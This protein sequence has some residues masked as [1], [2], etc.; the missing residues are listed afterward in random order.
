MKGTLAR[1]GWKSIKL[2]SHPP[3]LEKNPKMDKTII[4]AQKVMS[5]IKY[6]FRYHRV[7][8]HLSFVG[9][10]KTPPNKSRK[11]RLLPP[12]FGQILPAYSLA[13]GNRNDEC[14]IKRMWCNRSLGAV[15]ITCPT[16]SVMSPFN[17]SGGVISS[18]SGVVG[19]IPPWCFQTFS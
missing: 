2:L 17:I 14:E 9:Y 16:G 13:N 5:G 1:N 6:V 10:I 3:K 19:V 18:F 12:R 8:Q 15:E 7:S 11:A 4:N